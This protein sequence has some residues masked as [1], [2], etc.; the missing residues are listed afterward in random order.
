MKHVFNPSQTGQNFGSFGWASHRQV[1]R[2]CG[3]VRA[4]DCVVSLIGEVANCPE[5]GDALYSGPL[6]VGVVEDTFPVGSEAACSI[7][8]DGGI[9]AVVMERDLLSPGVY[10]V[11]PGLPALGR[12]FSADAG[13]APTAFVAFLDAE[14][15]FGPIVDVRAIEVPKD[16]DL[17]RP[18]AEVALCEMAHERFGEGVEIPGYALVLNREAL[19]VVRN[20]RAEAVASILDLKRLA[21]KRDA[22]VP[23]RD[24]PIRISYEGNEYF[25]ANKSSA[26]RDVLSVGPS[27]L[28]VTND[29]DAASLWMPLD[30]VMIA[31]AMRTACGRHG[32]DFSVGIHFP[33]AVVLTY[34]ID[35]SGEKEAFT[36][37]LA[38]GS[39]EGDL[40]GIA[41]WLIERE[42]FMP[43][44]VGLPGDWVARIISVSEMSEVLGRSL[45]YTR[46]PQDSSR[47]AEGLQAMTQRD[48]GLNFEG[49]PRDG[50][51]DL[52]RP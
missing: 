36:V 50:R 33:R 24:I 45:G 38:N 2:E 35:D 13:A 17:S 30:A 14:Q 37:M 10:A 3:G 9:R 42:F 6:G 46:V 20:V 34:E 43:D 8:F 12:I 47:L 7:R 41:D 15:D 11:F 27:G 19:G 51:A 40:A 49:G 29:L 1:S 5:K 22:A 44:A 26:S 18:D 4:G 23:A 48:Q 52:P 31:N 21:T 16:F 32:Y 28:R 25:L 39:R